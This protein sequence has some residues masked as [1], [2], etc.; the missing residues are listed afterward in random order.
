MDERKKT[1]ILYHIGN[2]KLE[3]DVVH[4][5][6]K[7]CGIFNNGVESVKDYLIGVWNETREKLMHEQNLN[8]LD[9]E[10]VVSKEDFGVTF[11]VSE[12]K[13]PIFFISFPDYN[14]NIAESSC[15]AFAITERGPRF[16]TMEHQ[17]DI[18]GNS[19]EFVFGEFEFDYLSNKFSHTNYGQLS[20]R[21]VTNFATRVLDILN[22]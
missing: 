15:V 17:L 5:Y 6:G 11:N 4:D 20:R 14:N 8:V 19:E 7:M 9:L 16:F 22:D 18:S 12:K 1:S 2:Y 10:R 21:T 3:Y 13:E